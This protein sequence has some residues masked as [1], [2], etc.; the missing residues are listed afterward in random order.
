MA[1]TKQSRTSKSNKT[2]T[3]SKASTAKKANPKKANKDSSAKR[4]LIAENFTFQLTI[5]A[6]VVSQG[7]QK[8][9]EV[10]RNR[11]KQ[12]GFRK[13]HAPDKIVEKTVGSQFLLQQTLEQIVPPAYEAE[14]QTQK[15]QPVTEPDI[16]PV[17]MEEGQDWV[18]EVAIAQRPEIK[19]DQYEE[20]VKKTKSKHELWQ[21]PKQ[22]DDQEKETPA[23]VIRQQQLQAVLT[24]LLEAIEVPVPELLLRKETEY[25]LH[26]L[27]HQLKHMNMSFEDFLKNSG[28]SREDVQQDYAA[29][30]LGNLQVELLLGAIIQ[31]AKLENSEQEVSEV[32]KQRMAQYPE[33]SQPQ[34]TARDIQY[35]NAMLLKQKALDHL[36]NL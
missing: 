20:I 15:L 28:K 19:V 2:D 12:D 24:D 1:E 21:E 33:G 36:L 9:L 31:A 4:K 5:P 23:E 14:L 3:K 34:I 27:E 26:E 16:K 29:R 32:L 35:V 8:A 7:R 18:F 25:Q 22:K 13:G 11:L 17:S 10:A 30:A 6:D